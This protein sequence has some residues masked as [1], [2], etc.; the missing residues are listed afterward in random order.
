MNTTTLELDALGVEQLDAETA[1]STDGGNPLVRLAI[2]LAQEAISN[3]DDIERGFS[4][5]YDPR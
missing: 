4:D 3:W 1:Q 5:S 2:W